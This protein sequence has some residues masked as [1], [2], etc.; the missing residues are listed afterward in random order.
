MNLKSIRIKMMFPIIFLALILAVL[1]ASMVYMNK[2]QQ[3]A[4]KVQSEH[5]FEA[6]AVV[7]NADRDLY[8]ARLA[9]EMM[10][11]EDGSLADNQKTFDENAE[12]VLDRF[13]KYRKYLVAEPEIVARFTAF[14]DQYQAWLGASRQVMQNFTASTKANT[15]LASLNAQF[16]ELR[17]MLDLAGEN[18]RK[19]ARQMEATSIT[20]KDL[21]S[22]LEAITEVLNADRDIYQARLAQQKIIGNVGDFSENKKHF[23]DNAQQVIQRL[24]RYR[25]ALSD[26]PELTEP[27]NN[28]DLLFNEWF[29]HSEQLL[30]Q[31][32]M[33][34]KKDLL[35]QAEL[36]DTEFDKLRDILDGAGEA[37]RVRARTAEK[38]VLAHI[39]AFQNTAMVIMVVAF[40][41]AILFGF[42]VPRKITQD[43]NNITRRI[44]EIAEGDGDLTQRI[45]STAKDELGA[46]S[47]QFDDFLGRLQSIIKSVS[48]QSAALGG[49]TTE[50]DN[51]SQKAEH[52]THGLVSASEQIVSAANEMT[53]S[54]QQ[55]PRWRRFLP[56]KQTARVI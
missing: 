35:S 53:M 46:L 17:R 10:L 18:L 11:T 22:F 2:A 12:Q 38:E 15:E 42:W 20:V 28:F 48:Q 13:K 34:A 44:K 16:V 3:E 39:S 51:V 21:E 36:S 1:F 25:S 5:Y 49:M 32:S 47:N 45:N 26:Y 7:L 52:I 40:I 33:M 43:V 19:K 27:Y 23:L 41:L 4:I 56:M 54:N 29:Q 55:W 31:P 14:D 24:N 37:V 9:Q 30:D 6:I 8:Q 50:L